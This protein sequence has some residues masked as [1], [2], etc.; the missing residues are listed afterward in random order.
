MI[1]LILKTLVL[2]DLCDVN[3]N[4][5]PE[6]RSRDK[7]SHNS[8]RATGSMP[9]VG[10]SRNITGGSPTSATAALSFRLFPPLKAYSLKMNAFHGHMLCFGSP[11]FV[12]SVPIPISCVL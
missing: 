5:L 4:V 6:A 3:T 7:V 11:D 12:S 2:T 8:R 9:V 10:S 1:S